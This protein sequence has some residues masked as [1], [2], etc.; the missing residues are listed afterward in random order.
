[1]NKDL[2]N[3][4]HPYD[5]RVIITFF[6]FFSLRLITNYFYWIYRNF[7]NK[8]RWLR[9]FENDKDSVHYMTLIKGIKKMWIEK[10]LK[11]VEKEQ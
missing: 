11:K 9:K 5:Y 4:R 6:L 2:N 1:M 10:T 3:T 8:Y 7:V